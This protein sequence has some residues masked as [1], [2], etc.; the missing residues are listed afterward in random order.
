M[1]ASLDLGGTGVGLGVGLGVGTGVGV[2]LGGGVG[3]AEAGVGVLIGA[4]VGSEGLPPPA[5]HPAKMPT[6][7]RTVL[8]SK[9]VD[10]LEIR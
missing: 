9:T 2:G 7:A 5:A 10:R 3:V 8:L 6:K 1:K 4:G